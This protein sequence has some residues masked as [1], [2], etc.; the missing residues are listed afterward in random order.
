MKRK[1]LQKNN[2]NK[3][4]QSGEVMSILEQMSDGIQ[5]VSEQHGEIIK[6]L[7]EHDKRF[8]KLEEKVDRLQDDMT[9]VK[10]KLSEKV[11]R[12]EFNKMEKRLVKLEKLV[13]AKLA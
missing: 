11:D 5:L 3:V 2:E 10:H 6:K 7:G 12:E 13:L 1:G 9:E 4:F 8:D